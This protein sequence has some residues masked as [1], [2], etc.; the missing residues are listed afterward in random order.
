MNT[1]PVLAAPP[2]LASRTRKFAR[3]YRV[4]L[5]TACAFALVLIAAAVISIRQSI[6]ANR[7]AAV[8][9]AV[10]DFLQN[11]VLVQASASKQAGPSAKPDPDLKVRTALDRAAQRIP[12]KFDRQP[13]VEASIRD[14]MGQTY[15]DLG[16]YPEARKQLER[17][18]DWHRRLL[19]A[20]N[21]KTLKT[22]SR[23]GRTAQLQGKYA[24][25]ETLLGRALEIERRVL[26]P[27][28]PDTL[29]SMNNLAGVYDY[30]GKYPQAEALDS[31]TLEIQRRVLGPEHPA[32]LKSMNN[33]PTVY[34]S[35]GKY[36]QAE[37][38]D[39]QTLEIRRRVLGPEHPDT[40]YSMNN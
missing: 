21:P 22:M 8:A 39:S 20:E 1:E 7:E 26:G 25:A 29:Y 27:A 13:E 31:Q 12:G 30:Q 23:L 28:H 37:A 32:T 10:N 16:L 6:R 36:P 17:A 34:F 19:G 33:L 24:E 35:Q 40:L 3:R 2:S 15:V 14:T 9:Q 38:L 5:V 11:D 4:A 18:R